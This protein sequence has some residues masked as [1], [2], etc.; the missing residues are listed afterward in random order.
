MHRT[1]SASSKADCIAACFELA[2]ASAIGATFGQVLFSSAPRGENA[3]RSSSSKAAYLLCDRSRGS[4]RMLTF[5]GLGPL[6][7]DSLRGELCLRLTLP[8]ER[9]GEAWDW[10]TRLLTFM[11]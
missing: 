8:R 1:N 6:L 9:I 10:T 4:G 5:T 3:S 2:R 11:A 7:E